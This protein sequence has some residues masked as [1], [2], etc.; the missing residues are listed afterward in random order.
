MGTHHT[1]DRGA[2]CWPSRMQ[3]GAT[4]TPCSRPAAI[5][6]RI[7]AETWIQVVFL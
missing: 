3:A 6:G 7:N 4:T 5:D 2:L 1:C